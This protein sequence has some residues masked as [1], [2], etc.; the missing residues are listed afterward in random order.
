[1]IRSEDGKLVGLVFVDMTRSI[2]NYVED[3]RAVIARDVKHLTGVSILKSSS[4]KSL[5]VK[6]AY[7]EVVSD[8][9]AS[10]AVIIAGVIMRSCARRSQCRASPAN[11]TSSRKLAV[12]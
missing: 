11:H 3:A 5:N 8:L 9:L 10:I 4:D 1:M 2:A 7:F 12:A 6:E